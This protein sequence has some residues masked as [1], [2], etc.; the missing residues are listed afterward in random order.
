RALPDPA[1]AR[2]Q[3]SADQTA[4]NLS[5]SNAI[6]SLR[7][8]GDADWPDL[9]AR[10]STLMRLM[11]GSPVFEAEQVATRDRTLHG[12]ERLAL[13]SGRSE[14]AVA[15]ALLGLMRAA[16]G[17]DER[18]ATASHWLHGAGRPA[19]VQALGLNGRAAQRWQG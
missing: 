10:T 2:T 7:A 19:L 8:I 12:I 9:V 14:R 3:Q 18:T 5:V 4:D 6:T 1:A 13:H 16:D 15:E 17:G 11:L